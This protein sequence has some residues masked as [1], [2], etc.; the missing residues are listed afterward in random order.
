MIMKY[1]EYLIYI[2]GI[3]A[4]LAILLGAFDFV[5]DIELFKVN[6]DINYFHA[7]SSFLLV[8]ISCI[9]YLILKHK[10]SE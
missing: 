2:F 4:G 1:L 3:L 6:H 10:K 9:L 7:A 5:F 8:S